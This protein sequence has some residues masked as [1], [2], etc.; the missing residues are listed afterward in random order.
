M[1]T[2]Q[3]N[4]RTETT[5]VV[6]TAALVRAYLRAAKD[7]RTIKEIVD[8]IDRKPYQVLAELGNRLKRGDVIREYSSGVRPQRY[9]WKVEP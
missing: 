4:T 5:I 6:T 7:W 1:N 3:I 9:R 8:A 2:G